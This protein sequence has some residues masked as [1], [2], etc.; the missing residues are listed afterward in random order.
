M[1]YIYNKRI[2]NNYYDYIYIFV[3]L[4]VIEITFAI[5][6]VFINELLVCCLIM[7]PLLL[8]Y[9]IIMSIDKRKY[10]RKAIIKDNIITVYYGEK[11][12]NSMDLSKVRK[13]SVKV[14]VPYGKAYE[15]NDFIVLHNES[16]LVKH[17][18]KLY[19]FKKELIYINNPVLIEA[20][21][22]YYNE[23]NKSPTDFSQ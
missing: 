19:G 10:F 13:S 21:N 17:N 11:I 1:E 14:L 12:V 8:M 23:W 3:I 18:M 6:T 16:P 20:L 2:R 15:K 9:P 7:L 5:A 22:T 4:I